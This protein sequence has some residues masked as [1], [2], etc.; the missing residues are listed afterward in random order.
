MGGTRSGGIGKASGES[1]CATRAVVNSRGCL[2]VSF[3]SLRA[4]SV[5]TLSCWFALVGTLFGRWD[6]CARVV[7]LGF[8]LMYSC[9]TVLERS[10]GLRAIGNEFGGRCADCFELLAPML[11]PAALHAMGRAACAQVIDVV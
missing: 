6:P 4:S 2:I 5:P 3:M 1:S 7:A 10:E 8:G 9:S 11:A